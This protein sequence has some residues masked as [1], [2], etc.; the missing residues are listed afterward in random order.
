MITI[1]GLTDRQRTLMDL[2]WTCSSL[3]QVRELI[4]ALPTRRDQQ[5]AESL[6]DVLTWE[7][8]EQ[9]LGF[10]EEVKDAASRAIATAMR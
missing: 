3:E 2:L 7:S 8:I 10:S 4:A 9:E 6:I 5:D 1:T